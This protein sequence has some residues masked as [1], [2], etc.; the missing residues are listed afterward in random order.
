MLF[1]EENKVIPSWLILFMV[2]NIY[3]VGLL[4]P[5]FKKFFS[6]ID[7]LKSEKILYNIVNR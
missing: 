4:Y 2:E 1:I 3:S 6:E 5:D 7:L